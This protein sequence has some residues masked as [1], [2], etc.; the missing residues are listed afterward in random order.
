MSTDFSRLKCIEDST[1]LLGHG[2]LRK[3]NVTDYPT[4]KEIV[5]LCILYFYHLEQFGEHGEDIELSS[6]DETIGINNVATASTISSHF[7]PMRSIYGEYEIDCNQQASGTF[8][9]MFKIN[10]QQLSIGILSTDIRVYD[11]YCLKA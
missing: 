5:Y 6:T 11:S 7:S 8:E 3:M 2:F 10:S 9:W 1:K 4:P